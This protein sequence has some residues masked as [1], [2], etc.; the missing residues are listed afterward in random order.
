MEWNE[1]IAISV[2]MWFLYLI[3]DTIFRSIFAG[4]NDWKKRIVIHVKK[5]EDKND[6]SV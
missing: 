1:V 5:G 2:I 3:V 4:K 6:T